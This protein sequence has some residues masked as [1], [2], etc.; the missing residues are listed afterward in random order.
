MRRT[1][2][3]MALAFVLTWLFL[4]VTYRLLAQW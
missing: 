4:T 1:L 2:W 3:Q